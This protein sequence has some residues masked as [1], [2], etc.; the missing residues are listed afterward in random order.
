MGLI[1]FV[2]N[3]GRKLDLNKDNDKPQQPKPRPSPARLS[4]PPRPV[5]S[6]RPRSVP[7]SRP[8]STWSTRWASR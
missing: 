8:W 1:E 7:G 4:R 2:K 6:P 3:V 5:I